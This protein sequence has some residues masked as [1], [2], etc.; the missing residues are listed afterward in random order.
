LSDYSSKIFKY[1]KL[2]KELK[3]KGLSARAIAKVLDSSIIPVLK[4]IKN[5]KIQRNVKT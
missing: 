5:E 2:I 4:I 1:W 3:A